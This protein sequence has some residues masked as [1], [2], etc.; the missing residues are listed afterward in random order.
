M[1][2]D[3]RI[4][5]QQELVKAH[6]TAAHMYL[7]AMVT[8]TTISAQYTQLTQHITELQHDLKMIDLLIHQGH[9]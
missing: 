8:Q 1:L 7:D 6:N 3:R 2:K 5:V 9:Q 4:L